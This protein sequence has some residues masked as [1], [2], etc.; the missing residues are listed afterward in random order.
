MDKFQNLMHY[1]IW[2][3]KDH[4]SLGATKLAKI[5]WYADANHFIQH[6]KSIT[7][8]VYEKRQFGPFPKGNM[9]ARKA[10]ES[11]RKIFVQE[12]SSYGDD[13]SGTLFIAL[14]KPQ[15]D[16]FTAE[17]ISLVDGIIDDIC[18][19][20]TA[21]SISDQSHDIIWDAASIG[22]EIPLHAVFASRIGELTGDDIEWAKQQIEKWGHA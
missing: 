3:C 2:K 1:I 21:K 5:L 13:Y 7:G 10:L 20:H 15:I 22:E 11:S 4:R 18:N 14:E 6:G 16:S 17:E 19:N 12:S 8:A 9:Q